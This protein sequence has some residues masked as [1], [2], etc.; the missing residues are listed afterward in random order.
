MRKDLF[1]H[2]GKPEKTL[3][4][5]GSWLAEEHVF[6]GKKSPSLVYYLSSSQCC[7][8]DALWGSNRCTPLRPTWPTCGLSAMLLGRVLELKIN[9]LLCCCFMLF[10]PWPSWLDDVS[11][12]GV[13][14][15]MRHVSING[16][17]S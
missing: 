6:H 13:F 17:L 16:T 5:N 15:G 4:F 1:S 11:H 8:L 14:C 7:G 9:S 12:T 3:N 2:E 10:P